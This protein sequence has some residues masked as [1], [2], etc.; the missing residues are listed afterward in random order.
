ML[1]Q[2]VDSGEI[3]TGA[4]PA[5]PRSSRTSAFLAVAVVSLV[6]ALAAALWVGLRDSGSPGGPLRLEI[7]PPEGRILETGQTHS[8]VLSP[9]GSRVALVLDD[10]L[11][12]RSL[13]S[14]DVRR[15]EQGDVLH[16]FWC[17]E[18]AVFP[19]SL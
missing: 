15:I 10:G 8:I 11:W 17:R 16:P 2:E 12:I 4:H 5:A 9:D 1:R 7:V 6:V 14:H 19:G 18:S 3:I 13:A